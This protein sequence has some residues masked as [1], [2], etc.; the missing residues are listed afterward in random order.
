MKNQITDQELQS[1]L[2]ALP[3]EIS[4]E[5]DVWPAINSRIG[6]HSAAN[7]GSGSSNRWWIRAAAAS[8]A[9]AITAGI[10]LEREWNPASGTAQIGNTSMAQSHLIR[11][12]ALSGV[13]AASEAQYQAAF[14]E[15]IAV[16]DTENHVTN[17]TLEKLTAG[18]TEMR[19]SELG[20]STA[21]QQDPDNIFL[22]RKMLELRSRQLR[23]LKQIAAL[24][25]SS[26]RRM[27]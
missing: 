9:L 23:F 20:L 7:P 26:R 27:I 12:S 25:K 18:W 24:D 11:S 6:G 3:R 2:D 13:V 5:N 17:Q 21:L 22:N 14:R 4:P 19:E 15:F 16:G 10:V 1:K 8:V